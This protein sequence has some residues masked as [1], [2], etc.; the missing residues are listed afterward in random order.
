MF[1]DLQKEAPSINVE[2]PASVKLHIV[3]IREEWRD[4][5]EVT[6][7]LAKNYR[8]LAE[9]QGG[10]FR[11]AEPSHIKQA[12]DSIARNHCAPMPRGGE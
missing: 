8:K 12:F 9:L 3:S 4:S 11:L 10:E 5:N 6:E 1:N 2:L 7:R